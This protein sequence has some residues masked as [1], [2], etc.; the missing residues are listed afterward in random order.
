VQ[1]GHAEHV[2]SIGAGA[3]KEH[4]DHQ[5]VDFYKIWGDDK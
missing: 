5:K 3:A 1:A 4:A 2:L